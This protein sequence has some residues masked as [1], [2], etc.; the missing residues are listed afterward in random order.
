MPTLPTAFVALQGAKIRLD[1]GTLVVEHQAHSSQRIPIGHIGALVTLGAVECTTAAQ[2]ALAA[3]HVTCVHA[4]R[5]GL[6]KAVVTHG[7][8]MDLRCAALCH[9]ISLQPCAHAS[10][11]AAPDLRLPTALAAPRLVVA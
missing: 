7:M 3:R 6:I 4:S 8:R 1:G 11:T 2:C 10:S 9:V 5:S